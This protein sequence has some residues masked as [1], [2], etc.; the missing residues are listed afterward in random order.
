MISLIA[1]VW[2]YWIGVAIAIPTILVCVAIPLLYVRKVVRPRYP[3][4]S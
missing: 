1:V 4:R 2:S 3:P